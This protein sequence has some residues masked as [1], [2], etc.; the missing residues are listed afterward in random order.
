MSQQ[1]T[2]YTRGQPAALKQPR[3][4][5]PSSYRA[6]TRPAPRVARTHDMEMEGVSISLRSSTDTNRAHAGVQCDRTH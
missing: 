6:P 3:A 4:H 2:A 1:C 5:A